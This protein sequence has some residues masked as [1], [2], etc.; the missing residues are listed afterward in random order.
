MEVGDRVQVRTISGTITE[1][2]VA[3]FTD[4]G[5]LLICTNEE[6]DAALAENREPLWVGWPKE[7]I[8]GLVNPNTS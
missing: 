7:H 1:R 8:V 6:Y 4:E 2:R 5:Q 3:G